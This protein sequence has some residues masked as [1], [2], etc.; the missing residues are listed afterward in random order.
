MAGIRSA[1]GS[2][3]SRCFSVFLRPE[4]ASSIA[5]V[6]RGSRYPW[7]SSHSTLPPQQPSSVFVDRSGLVSQRRIRTT[8]ATR[9]LALPT[10]SSL[11]KFLKAKG[12]GGIPVSAPRARRR[13]PVVLT[14]AMLALA[15]DRHISRLYQNP[16]HPATSPSS[17][18]RRPPSIPLPNANRNQRA[19]DPA[20]RDPTTNTHSAAL[21]RTPQPNAYCRSSPR[22]VDLVPIEIREPPS[23]QSAC[24][25]R[26]I[27]GRTPA[28][29][30]FDF[31]EP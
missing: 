27:S 13:N 4:G 19:H 23:V 30:F 1:M 29:K 22:P 15:A 12:T 14:P 21:R 28:P 9:M 16:P 5:C 31:R 8:P 17:P 2:Q 6:I 7:P 3:S 20:S 25:E 26:A 24:A 11:L 10:L 18:A